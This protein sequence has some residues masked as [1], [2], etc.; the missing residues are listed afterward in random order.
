MFNIIIIEHELAFLIFRSDA[1]NKNIDEFGRS[2]SP[3]MKEHTGI[4]QAMVRK[5]IIDSVPC[6]QTLSKPWGGLVIKLGRAIA[7]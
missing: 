7:R 5:K 6:N 1:I 3:F 4:L 2:T